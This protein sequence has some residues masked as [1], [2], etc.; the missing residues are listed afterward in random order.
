MSSRI[1]S[2]QHWRNS[3]PL[4]SHDL[5]VISP[6][7][8]IPRGEHRVAR[9]PLQAADEQSLRFRMNRG[10]SSLEGEK[11]LSLPQVRR[12]QSTRH[13]P[14]CPISPLCQY[15]WDTLPLFN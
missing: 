15:E 7:V 14:Q 3:F 6:P 9:D 11:N 13:L 8:P 4:D 2:W 5:R 1:L 12:R 10:C